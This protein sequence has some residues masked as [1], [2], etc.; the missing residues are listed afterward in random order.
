MRLRA[1]FLHHVELPNHFAVLAAIALRV[2]AAYF[3]A[4]SDVIEPVAFDQRRGADALKRPVIG[5]AGGQFIVH[6]L[7]EKLAV[8]FTEGHQDAF[9]ARDFGIFQAFVV[10]SDV[11]CSA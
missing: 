6:I 8:G 7:P 9:I 11:N 3:A 2:E 4:I 1:N 5:A 10:G